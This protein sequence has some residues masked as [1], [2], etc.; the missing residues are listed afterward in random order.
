MMAQRATKIS[1][2]LVSAS[3]AARGRNRFVVFETADRAQLVEP[4]GRLQ[5]APGPPVPG[6]ARGLAVPHALR[7]RARSVFRLPRND[8]LRADRTQQSFRR[9]RRKARFAGAGLIWARITGS[10]VVSKPS[11]GANGAAAKGLS[12]SFSR[13]ASVAADPGGAGLRG[14][15]GG[16]VVDWARTRPGSADCDRDAFKRSRSERPA[17]SCGACTRACDGSGRAGFKPLGISLALRGRRLLCPRDS[18]AKQ[19]DQGKDKS[20]ANGME[21]R[22]GMGAGR[23]ARVLRRQVMNG[24][25]PERMR[26]DCLADRPDAAWEGPVTTG[27]CRPALTGRLRLSV[28]RPPGPRDRISIRK[29]GWWHPSLP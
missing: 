13:S 19:H 11:I 23:G 20:K 7:N 4:S 9:S 5:P 26:I 14:E 18:T 6:R 3:A 17:C 12:D 27:Q 16:G 1:A 25:D 8:L 29:P 22:R 28:A 24:A 2:N 21:K 10:A 15:S